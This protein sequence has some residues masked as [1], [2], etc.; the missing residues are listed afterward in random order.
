MNKEVP[1][2]VEDLAEIYVI[3]LSHSAHKEIPP[4]E[5]CYAE[6]QMDIPFYTHDWTDVFNED[7]AMSKCPPS[8]PTYDF[9]INLE[10]NTK[11]PPPACPYHLS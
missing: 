4:I 10:E 5:Q 7:L 1:P 9:E 2:M 11:L 6:I 3:T 8:H